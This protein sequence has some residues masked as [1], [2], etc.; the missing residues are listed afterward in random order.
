MDNHFNTPAE[1]IELNMKA[2]ENKT[3]LPL[4]KMILLVLFP[5]LYHLS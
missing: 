5:F 4:G 2:S 1:T 3:A